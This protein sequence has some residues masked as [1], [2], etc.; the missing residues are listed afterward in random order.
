MNAVDGA[1]EI[2]F[3]S[4]NYENGFRW[5]EDHFRGAG[6]AIAIGEVSPSYFHECAAVERA[7]CYRPW[8]KIVVSLRDPVERALSQH[9]HMVRLGRIPGPDLSFETALESNPTYVEQGLYHSHLRRWIDAFGASNV[10]VIVMD[11]IARDRAR[12]ARDLYQFLGVN[13][14]HTPAAL[15]VRSNPSYVIRNQ[16]LDRSVRMAR[17]AMNAAGAGPLWKRLGDSGLRQAY[18]SLNRTEPERVIPPAR[19][20]TLANLRR[21]FDDDVH[22]LS[23]LLQRNLDTWRSRA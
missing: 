19:P 17:K 5:Y 15:G 2:D 6:S 20:E 22:R 4:Y 23:M 13:A 3:F 10:H 11:D 12:V 7:R 8:L 9:R 14:S 16:M 21:L 1:K 18:R